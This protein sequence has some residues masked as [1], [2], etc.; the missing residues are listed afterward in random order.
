MTLSEIGKDRV[1]DGESGQGVAGQGFT[2]KVLG[3]GDIGKI[4]ERAA[5]TVAGALKRIVRVLRDKPADFGDD[6]VVNA[7]P[8][9]EDSGDDA[10]SGREVDA[11]EAWVKNRHGVYIIKDVGNGSRASEN[12]CDALA[13]CRIPDVALGVGC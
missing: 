10:G 1:S 3:Q 7:G 8:G 9:V 5:E 2:G 11:G 13:A 6:S 12:D 4:G